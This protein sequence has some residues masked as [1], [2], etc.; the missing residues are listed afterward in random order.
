MVAAAAAIIVMTAVDF[1]SFVRLLLGTWQR[2]SEISFGGVFYSRI[3]DAMRVLL[4]NAY[5]NKQTHYVYS[6]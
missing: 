4:S 6:M 3:C 5:T 2:A 1:F